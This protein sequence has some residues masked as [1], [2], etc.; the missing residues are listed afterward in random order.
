MTQ[1]H[2]TD[3]IIAQAQLNP[4][5][6]PKQTPAA[7]S[8]IITPDYDGKLFDNRFDYRSIIGQLNFL[9]K[10]TRPDIAYAVHQCARFSARPK[11]SH[12]KAIEHIVSYLKR[13]REHE[14]IIKPDPTKSLEVFANADFSGNWYRPDAEYDANT[15]KSRTGYIITFYNCPIV[16][17]SKI[18]TTIALSSTE[19]EYV[20]LS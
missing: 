3:Q 7:S 13:T 5:A 1:P 17:A 8:K 12:G 18:Q 16:W 20:A 6:E 15:A 19:A 14:I 11:Q 9:E 2:I 10:S 4:K